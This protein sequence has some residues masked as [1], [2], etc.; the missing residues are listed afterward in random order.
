V[1]FVSSL[2]VMCDVMMLAFWVWAVHLWIT[3]LDGRNPLALGAAAL[4]IAAS[5]LTKYFGMALIPL[6]LL[7]SLYAKRRFGWWVVYLAVPVA[8]LGWY[9]WKTHALYG[10][11]LLLDAASYATGYTA[12]QTGS[13]FGNL[14][15]AKTYVALAFTGGCLATLACFARSLWSRAALAVFT[16]TAI[17]ATLLIASSPTIGT[18]QLPE[19][20]SGRWLVAL[21]LGAWGTAGLS[22]LCLAALDFWRSRDAESLLIVLWTVGTFVFA[23]FIN[24]TTNGRSIL[25]MVIPA[26]I[27]IARR[28]DATGTPSSRW[29]PRAAVPLGLA[30]VLSIAVA[31]A[32][33]AFGE[34]A[35]RG[36]EAISARHAAATRT[37]WFQ[38]HWGFQYYMEQRGAK[39]V[40][41]EKSQ[42]ASGDRVVVPSTN[43]NIYPMPDWAK[44]IDVIDVPS[45]RWLATMNTAVGAGFYADVFG[46]LPFAVGS[47]APERFTVYE[48]RLQSSNR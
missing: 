17:V 10:R 29:L 1:F 11:G 4:L 45:S 7:Y 3:G 9:Q 14:S 48:V 6:L 30:A 13:S 21:Q 12:E 27:L 43:T 44:P 32:D 33:S 26:G 28:L 15:V 2:T 47:I 24:W 41:V 38:G 36:A 35:R 5:A 20:D 40:D 42:L 8:V 34:T 25:P 16:G 31:W 22:L 37:L 18:F 46:P 39:P 23:G 19:S